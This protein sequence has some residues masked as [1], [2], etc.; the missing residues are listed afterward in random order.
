MAEATGRSPETSRDR[1]RIVNLS[2]GVFAIAITLL[3]LDIHVPEMPENLVAAELP[4]ALLALWPKYLGYFLSF[5]GIST[6]WTIHQ[7]IFR[8]IRAYDRVLLYLNFLFLRSWRSSPSHLAA[9]R[10][11]QPPTPG[12]HLRRHARHR[13]AAIDGHPLVLD[14][15]RPAAGGGSGPTDGT[16][17]PDPEPDHTGHLLAL[18]RH[19]LLQRQRGHLDM[20]HRARR[21]RDHPS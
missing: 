21:R 10:V 4:A 9:R 15:G 11:R 8:P 18:D 19:L 2:D 3:I 14:D 7:S 12:G 13:Q 5:V 16:L 20:V 6:F 1:D 17:L